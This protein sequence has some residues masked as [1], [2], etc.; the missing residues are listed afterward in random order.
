[1][2]HARLA[3]ILDSADMGQALDKVAAVARETRAKRA[4]APPV[5]EPPLP[6]IPV[7]QPVGAGNDGV[8]DLAKRLLGGPISTAGLNAAG[9]AGSILGNAALGAGIGGLSNTVIDQFRDKKNKRGI[10]QAL[11]EGGGVGAAIGGTAGAFHHGLRPAPYAKEA[12]DGDSWLSGIGKTIGDAAGTA[13]SA[14][15]NAAQTAWK[16]P[17]G[18]AA[19]IGGG[20][21]LAGGGVASLLD[22][23]KR[24]RWL[25]NT[26]TAGLLGS[27]VG[28]GGRMTY[29][30]LLAPRTPE[31]PKGETPQ[32]APKAPLPERANAA[33]KAQ[34]GHRELGLLGYDAKKTHPVVEGLQKG[35]LTEDQ[36]KEQLLAARPGKIE[37]LHNALPA[38]GIAAGQGDIT[39]AANQA[40]VLGLKNINPLSTH[41]FLGDAGSAATAA[42]AV[43]GNLLARDLQPGGGTRKMLSSLGDR[44]ADN[45]GSGHNAQGRLRWNLPIASELAAK[46]R[47]RQDS[48]VTSELN[49]RN[50]AHLNADSKNKPL[51]L[52]HLGP[53][54]VSQAAKGQAPPTPWERQKTL[55]NARES[56]AGRWNDKPTTFQKVVGKGWAPAAALL[57][58]L[59]A[60]EWG[61]SGF[62]SGHKP[63]MDIVE[64]NKIIH[65]G[66]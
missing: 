12:A 3:D 27:A 28:A 36:A 2:R 7:D 38:A 34:G 21:G 57:A 64:A 40:D 8:P 31:A 39:G 30:N 44:F 51:D 49:A 52:D 19:V 20:L 15:S 62:R 54:A 10:L 42:T 37:Q 61:G 23:E 35:D 9:Y 32:A 33:S 25:S 56:R 17:T 60:R 63:I 43:G 22:K 18:Q 50:T 24:K 1:M 53:T 65:G 41:G 16:D 47:G 45:F 46:M 11:L 59:L 48:I 5:A 55:Q 13:G 14:I 58:P 4:A 26:M 6:P 66:K 29:D